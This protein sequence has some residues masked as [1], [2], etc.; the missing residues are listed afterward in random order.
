M[1]TKK[2]PSR[3]AR[4]RGRARETTR[5]ASPG[6]GAKTRR[7]EV[8]HSGVYPASG[9]LPESNAPAQGMAS[10]GQGERGA[11]GYED[12]G[13]SELWFTEQE[14]RQAGRTGVGRDQVQPGMEVYGADGVPIGHV[15]DVR[16]NAVLVQ[17]SLGPAMVVPFSACESVENQGLRLNVASNAL[18]SQGWT[19]PD[20]P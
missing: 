3:A 11:A 9:P 10:W 5:E 12:S 20:R 15:K 17:R 1:A 19:M 2:N 13:T 6:E 16:T 8:G 14:L 4:K 7:D 18:D